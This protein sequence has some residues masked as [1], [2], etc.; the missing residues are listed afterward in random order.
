MLARPEW[1]KAPKVKP[2]SL[3]GFIAWLEQQSA[4]TEY[5]WMARC[6]CVVAQ[7]R[8]FVF[9][10]NEG[11]TLLSDMLGEDSLVEYLKIGSTESHTFGAALQRA[12]EIQSRRHGLS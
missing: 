8:L 11:I 4:D 2:Q 12:R 9:G 10:T 7:Y 5:E 3:E 1:N 6:S